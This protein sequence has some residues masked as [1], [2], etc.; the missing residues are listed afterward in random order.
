MKLNNYGY[1]LAIL[2]VGSDLNKNYANQFKT[3]RY[4]GDSFSFLAGCRPLPETVGQGSE[5]FGIT[6]L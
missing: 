6:R 5:V 2:K 1:G 4:G 3:G